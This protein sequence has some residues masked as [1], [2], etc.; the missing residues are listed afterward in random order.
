[1]WDNA[2]VVSQRTTAMS[3]QTPSDPRPSRR[4]DLGFDEFIAI[5]V[6]FAAIG[7]IL[8]WGLTRKDEGVNLA[9][10]SARPTVAPILPPENLLPSASPGSSPINGGLTL[11]QGDAARTSGISSSVPATQVSP[12]TVSAAPHAAPPFIVA[13]VPVAPPQAAPSPANPSQATTQGNAA[14]TASVAPPPGLS[15]PPPTQSV[16]FADVPES[17]WAYPF[18]AVLAQRGIVNG[19]DSNSFRPDQPITRAEYA[20]L[21]QKI[22][23]QPVSQNPIVF[24]DVP[25]NFWAASAI[26]TAVKTGFM[27]GYPEGSFQPEQQIPRVQVLA[28]LANGL[29][30]AAPD[31]AADVVKVYRDSAEIPSWATPATAAATRAGMVVN[32]PDLD[33]LGPNQPATR[34]EVA[35]MIHQALVAAGK[36]PPVQSNYVVHP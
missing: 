26:D 16:Q 33:R 11:P 5:L 23:Q 4:R 13:P 21:I 35:A 1:M 7:S 12:E 27:K 31:S 6:A 9:N 2:I 36:L 19:V 15:V 10:S 20:V 17:Y 28:S 30:V 22:F 24:K 8:V 25:S 34:A 3:N 29:Q 32:H 14:P 18:I